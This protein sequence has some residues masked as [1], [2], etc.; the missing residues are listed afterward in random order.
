MYDPFSPKGPLLLLLPMV[1]KGHNTWGLCMCCSN[2]VLHE[3]G[4]VAGL[5]C[6]QHTSVMDE[7]ERRATAGTLKVVSSWHHRRLD[8]SSFLHS[9]SKV[10]SISRVA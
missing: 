2:L 10:P 9:I 6:P 4:M 8:V 5:G 3:K 7:L 1:C